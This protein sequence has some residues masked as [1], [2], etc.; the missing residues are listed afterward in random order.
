MTAETPSLPDARRDAIDFRDAVGDG[1][2]PLCP[3]L[4]LFIVLALHPHLDR[5]QQ[6]HR[7]NPK[8]CFMELITNTSDSRIT[9]DWRRRPAAS[10]ER[11]H[12][13]GDN[14]IHAT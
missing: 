13:A 3:G 12:Q 1:L 8:D 10:S 2:H 7:Y 6:A 5:G 14:S 4:V 9:M 11:G